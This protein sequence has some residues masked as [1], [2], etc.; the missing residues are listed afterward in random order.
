M[1]V[2]LTWPVLRLPLSGV[3]VSGL[4][5]SAVA[6]AL[7]QRMPRPHAVVRRSCRSALWRG[8]QRLRRW[9][10]D[11]PP[12]PLLQ[13]QCC[14]P[15][16]PRFLAWALQCKLREERLQDGVVVDWRWDSATGQVQGLLWCGRRLERFHWLPG[17]PQLVR[18]GVLE[19]SCAA[20]PLRL[21]GDLQPFTP[22]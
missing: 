22:G 15:L 17:L 2:S 1:P 18:Q 4:P 16:R 7:G 20:T 19:L 13:G 3:S 5:G 8:L 9:V 14:D 10:L 6:A 21:V 12:A 11:Q